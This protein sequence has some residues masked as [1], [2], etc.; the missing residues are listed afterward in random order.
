MSIGL[1]RGGTFYL[2]NSNTA[3]PGDVV[4]TFGLSSHTP[5]TGNWDGK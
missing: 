3:G 5:L 2:R 4:T 1:W